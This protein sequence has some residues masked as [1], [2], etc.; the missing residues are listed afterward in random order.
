MMVGL[1]VA[2][3]VLVAGISLVA[4]LWLAAREGPVSETLWFGGAIGLSAIWVTALAVNILVADE[5][6]TLWLQ[7]VELAASSMIPL[8]WLGFTL[9]YVGRRDWLNAPTFMVLTIVPAATVGILL[10]EQFYGVGLVRA[11]TVLVTVDGFRVAGLDPG[12]WALV[13]TG[14]SYLLLAMAIALAV[15]LASSNPSPYREQGLVLAGAAL[16]PLGVSVP[17]LVAPDL[18]GGLDP[19]PMALAGTAILLVVGIRRYGLLIDVPMPIHVAHEAVL[20]S[21]ESPLVVLN[22]AGEIRHTNPSIRDVVHHE[23]AALLGVHGDVLP[24]IHVDESGVVT[25]E[26]VIDVEG[27][28]TDR[29]YVLHTTPL[30]DGRDRRFGTIVL[31]QDSTDLYLRE[32]RLNVLNRVLRHDIRNEMSVILGHAQDGLD[33]PEGHEHHFEVIGETARSV[34]H[35]A[36]SARQ[37]ERLVPMTDLYSE[38]TVAEAFDRIRDRLDRHHVDLTLHTALEVPPDAEVPTGFSEVLWH[39]IDSGIDRRS[40]ASTASVR[41]ERAGGGRLAVTVATDGSSIPPE[42]LAVFE[43]GEI[44]QLDHASGLGLWLVHWVVGEYGG[45]VTVDETDGRVS[46]TVTLPQP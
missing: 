13:Q 27:D 25:V 11:E 20:E 39:L 21:L 19:T 30:T 7:V 34:V 40:P 28:P 3:L 9:A 29:R 24:G 22:T 32:Q 8:V 14:F 26:D 1:A 5:G 36:D 2:A 15:D 33:D 38:G 10:S 41:V 44:T 16:V 6:W 17:T 45:S 35:T 43:D 46:V 12:P 31:Y 18:T 4:V 23:P 42:E 37:I